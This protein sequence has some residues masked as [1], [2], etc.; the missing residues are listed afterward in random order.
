M[1]ADPDAR[2]SARVMNAF[3]KMKK[4]DLES[5]TRAYAGQSA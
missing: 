2:K 5:I 3:M 4:L 1:M